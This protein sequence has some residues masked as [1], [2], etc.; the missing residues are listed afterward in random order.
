APVVDLQVH[1]VRP[2]AVGDT[3]TV[4]VRYLDSPAAKLC[5][6]YEIRR[7]SDGEVVATGSSVQVFVDAQGELCL[8]LPDFYRQWRERWLKR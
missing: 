3:A 2:L 4:E 7:D 8:A 1:Y 5:F 6:E